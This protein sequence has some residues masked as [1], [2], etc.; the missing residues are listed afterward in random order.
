MGRSFFKTGLVIF[1][2]VLLTSVVNANETKLEQGGLTKGEVI[3][4]SV[5]GVTGA[6]AGITGSIAA[7][8]ASGQ[9][10]GLSAAGITTGL[11]AIGGGSMIG[12]VIICTGGTAILVGAGIYGGYKLA[13]WW[14][15]P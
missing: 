3:G 12:G 2:I 14:N 10:A 1:V 6:G 13:R 9:V 4:S 7:I 8:S 11:S 5:G 15:T